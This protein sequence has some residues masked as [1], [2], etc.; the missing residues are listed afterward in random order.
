MEKIYQELKENYQTRNVVLEEKLDFV[1]TTMMNYAEGLSKLTKIDAAY[2]IE[3]MS[4]IDFIEFLEEKKTKESLEEIP[5][6]HR[7][8]SFLKNHQFGIYIADTRLPY[9]E[10]GLIR[11]MIN[12]C[13]QYK[14][15]QEGKL[16]NRNLNFRKDSRLYEGLLETIS[17]KTWKQLKPEEESIGEVEDRYFMEVQI[18]DILIDTMGKKQFL[19]NIFLNP[20]LILDK[21]KSCLYQGETLLNYLDQ[22]MSPLIPYHGDYKEVHMKS[23]DLLNSFEAICD[24]SDSLKLK[25]K[26]IGDCKSKVG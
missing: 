10:D 5:D 18:A 1:V 8:I 17:Q 14:K 11:E 13:I 23:I 9:Q 26:T 21:M 6:C 25:S 4:R 3:I 22:Q 12:I 15:N 24:C 7:T 2:F 19:E 16:E 20:N